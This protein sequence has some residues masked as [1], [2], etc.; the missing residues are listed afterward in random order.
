MAK[1][2]YSFEEM[3]EALR[4]VANLLGHVPSIR[5]YEEVREKELQ[6]HWDAH[7]EDIESMVAN[8][9]MFWMPTVVTIRSRYRNWGNAIT[10]I[11]KDFPNT[12]KNEDITY[13]EA[14]IKEK[15]RSVREKEYEEYRKDHPDAPSSV[16]LVKQFDGWPGALKAAGSIPTHYRHWRDEELLGMLLS[17]GVEIGR[18]PTVAEYDR[19]A[20]VRKWPVSRQI[21]RR[22]VS[23]DGAIAQIE[24]RLLAAVSKV[25]YKPN[26]KTLRLFVRE[27]KGVASLQGLIELAQRLERVPELREYN[28]ARVGTNWSSGDDIKKRYNGSWEQAL[29]AAGIDDAFIS[30]MLQHA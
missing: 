22:F 25:D 5:E 30:E 23:W 27:R 21:Y 13:L 1:P 26:P 8:K 24:E 20:K 18:A 15:G 29:E 28:R 6:S 16:S 17:L 14:L 2:V 10:E 7:P 19:A 3:Q 11:K 4:Y 12:F 9:K